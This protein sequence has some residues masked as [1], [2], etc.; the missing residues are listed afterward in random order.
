MKDLIL[1]FILFI[2]LYFLKINNENMTNDKNFNYLNNTSSIFVRNKIYSNDDKIEITK[3]PKCTKIIKADYIENTNVIVN[4]NISIYQN[5]NDL[6]QNTIEIDN[7]NFNL[8]S[9]RWKQS[10]FKYNNNNVGLELHLVHQ[11]FQS[12]NK[13]III[14]PLDFIKTEYE[15]IETFKN[16]GYYTSSKIFKNY[17]FDS[18]DEVKNINSSNEEKI[19]IDN[20]LSNNNNNDFN[21]KVNYDNKKIYTNKILLDTLLQ[22]DSIIPKYNC[23]VDTIGQV[24]RF[25]LCVPQEIVLKNIEYYQLEDHNNNIYYITEPIGIPSKLGFNIRNKIVMDNNV[26]FLRPI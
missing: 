17:N 12:I 4:N 7:K 26:V 25:N 20:N 3:L 9:I 2:F 18:L 19:I 13:V 16:I 24:V 8:T 10:K 23:C 1:I 15:S 5:M 21:L 14:I 6:L 11:N 22:S